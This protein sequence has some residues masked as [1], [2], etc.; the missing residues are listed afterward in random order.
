M[1]FV[2]S[3]V[4]HP[5]QLYFG[6]IPEGKYAT[7]DGYLLSV[8]SP[9]NYATRKKVFNKISGRHIINYNNVLIRRGPHP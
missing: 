3:K 7:P 1:L 8:L 6:N 9:L 2:C 4:C 5:K